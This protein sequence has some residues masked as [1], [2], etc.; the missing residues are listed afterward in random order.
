MRYDRAAHAVPEARR[1]AMRCCPLL[2]SLPF[3]FTHVLVRPSLSFFMAHHCPYFRG[4]R[5]LGVLVPSGGR[6]GPLLVPQRSSYSNDFSFNRFSLG[7]TGLSELAPS[8]APSW[9]RLILVSGSAASLSAS[10]GP[11]NR[12]FS[13]FCCVADRALCPSSCRAALLCRSP[14]EHRKCWKRFLGCRGT[15]VR[16]GD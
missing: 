16:P 14:A 8:Q 1:R 5:L 12:F 2:V 10:L 6:S 4:H 13:G 3:L 15:S 11:P 7:S 9:Q